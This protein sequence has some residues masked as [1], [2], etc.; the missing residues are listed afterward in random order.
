M[1]WETQPLVYAPPPAPA[2]LEAEVAAHQARHRRRLDALAALQSAEATLH[3]ALSAALAPME[4]PRSAWL[5]RVLVRLR[6]I[7]PALPQA[8]LADQLWA[9]H[10]RATASVLALGHQ[11]ALLDQELVGV[12]A[13]IAAIQ[14]Q[15]HSLS[16]GKIKA[17]AALAS[18]DSR[19]AAAQRAAG[20]GAAARPSAALASQRWA[21]HRDEGRF[22]AAVE[23]LRDVLLLHQEVQATFQQV[24]TVLEQL[25][26]EASAALGGLNRRISALATEAAA[27]EIIED[28]QA[29]DVLR[30]SLG[31]L[32]ES[33]STQATWMDRNIGSL[34]A[35]LAALDTEAAERRRARR[36][37]EEALDA[38]RA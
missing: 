2:E 36:E 24:S 6:L 32:A 25:H 30:E 16:A 38:H 7:E 12:Q 21:V 18:L 26:G 9:R 29:I 33:A 5:E 22:T 3:D 19:A 10:E 15:V 27:A 11:L 8:P 28:A 4:V 20:E 23:R 31:V 17:A 1:P 13:D 37:V 35:R 14:Q 34:S